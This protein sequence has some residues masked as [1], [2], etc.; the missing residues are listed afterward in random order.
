MNENKQE[1]SSNAVRGPWFKF[2]AADWRVGYEPDAYWQPGKWRH[3]KGGLT[4]G[5]DGGPY[6][7]CTIPGALLSHWTWEPLILCRM[8]VAGE[9]SG[10]PSLCCFPKMR[11]V[12]SWSWSAELSIKLASFA[13]TRFGL[14]CS[15]NEP[16]QTRRPD[17]IARGLVAAVIA[18]ENGNEIQALLSA[19]V[20][21]L[22]VDLS[23]K[24]KEREEQRR[25]LHQY[26]LGELPSGKKW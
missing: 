5:A 3:E 17:T 14:P 23:V 24:G 6:V 25:I 20:C 13:V 15:P 12:E 8:Q 4:I 2:I 9:G 7:S 11:I 19:H 21:L 16:D 1:V 22:L 26:I 10:N 18:A